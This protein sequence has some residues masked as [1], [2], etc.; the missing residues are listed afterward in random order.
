MAG[1]SGQGVFAFHSLEPR[2]Q[3]GVDR[4][5]FDLPAFDANCVFPALKVDRTHGN[6]GFSYAPSGVQSNLKLE[7]LPVR[8]AALVVWLQAGFQFV[9]DSFNVGIRKLLLLFTSDSFDSQ[10][11]A[12]IGYREFPP[13]SFSHDKPERSKIVTGRVLADRFNLFPGCA[14]RQVIVA[15][16][17]RDLRRV[18]NTARPKEQRQHVPAVQVNL[19]GQRVGGVLPEVAVNPL[20]KGGIARENFGLLFFCCSLA[21]NPVGRSTTF[22][23]ITPAFGGL[24]TNLPGTILEF[25][26][27]KWTARTLQQ[28][29][30]R[31][32]CLKLH[33]SAVSC[34]FPKQ[35]AGSK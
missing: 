12:R 16:R 29:S 27:P 24:P 26:V 21:Q 22:A 10:V 4:F 31:N 7:T 20:V 28:S 13:H 32:C 17:V 3:I 5:G 9:A 11:Q 15:Q 6:T 19:K 2:Q 34:Q 23:G 35:R 18:F 8:P 1:T 30:H 14:P 25:N 33:E